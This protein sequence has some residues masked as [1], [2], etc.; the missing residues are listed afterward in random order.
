M[1]VYNNG[2]IRHAR[3]ADTFNRYGILSLHT[4]LNLRV[5]ELTRVQA[6]H[7]MLA[8]TYTTLTPGNKILKQAALAL[9]L[10]AT[11]LHFVL[12]ETLN[13]RGTI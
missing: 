9:D 11:M 2:Q 6:M 12:D 1:S 8:L 5:A 4:T 10:H 13:E 7:T 3:S